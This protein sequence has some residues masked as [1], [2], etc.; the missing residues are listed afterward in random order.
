MK[1]KS[2]LIA[3]ENGADLEELTNIIRRLGFNHIY[4]TKNA[5]DAWSMMQVKELGCLISAWE[6]R[7]CP[8]Y[9]SYESSGPVTDSSIFHSF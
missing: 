9:P 5:G 8:V 6:W 4:Q 7:T 1:I 3:D 2:L